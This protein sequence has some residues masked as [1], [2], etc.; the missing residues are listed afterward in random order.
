M[1]VVHN[2]GGAG[3]LPAPSATGT[4]WSSDGAAAARHGVDEASG[5][6][7]LAASAAFVVK[8]TCKNGRKGTR[9]RRTGCDALSQAGSGRN[10]QESVDRGWEGAGGHGRARAA[11]SSGEE[12][13]HEEAEV[14][15]EEIGTTIENFWFLQ[16]S[17]R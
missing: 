3:L 6:V 8:A 10:R 17:Q 2:L 16:S 5:P 15:M 4:C 9:R 11:C 7:K 12:V 13:R 1:A 14:V